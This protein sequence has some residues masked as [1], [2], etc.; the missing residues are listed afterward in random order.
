MNEENKP[1][2][3]LVGSGNMGMAITE[4]IKKQHDKLDVILVDNISEIT[5]PYKNIPKI[6]QILIKEC[7]QDKLIYP[8]GK[9]NRRKRREQKRK[10]KK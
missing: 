10:N 8:D 5:N 6:E 2:V 7:N 1:Q 3:V 9:A 4:I